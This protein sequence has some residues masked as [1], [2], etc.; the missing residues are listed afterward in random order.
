ME[1]F[2]SEASVLLLSVSELLCNYNR[3]GTGLHLS[4]GPGL[5]ENLLHSC[6]ECN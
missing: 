3:N 2:G 1:K 5:L 4:Y 6:N